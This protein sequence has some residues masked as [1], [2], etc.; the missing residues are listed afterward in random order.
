MRLIVG[1]GNPG[2]EYAQSRHNLGFR[3]VEILAARW[4]LPLNRKGFDALWGQ[5]QAEG[6]AV[7]LAQPTTYMNLSGRAVV[8]LLKHWRLTP[9]NLVVIHD[10]LDVPFGRLKIVERGSAAGHRGVLSIQSVLGTEEFLRLKLGIGRPEP[11]VDPEKFVLGR[12]HPDEAE[13]INGL[14]ARAAAAV[15]VMLGEGLAAARN[16]F[17]GT[18]G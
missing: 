1:L 17:H 16:K 2:R 15:E 8:K 14:V 11:G 4:E 6:T 3:V 10:D 9:E 18:P 12:F 5:G 7:V 13:E